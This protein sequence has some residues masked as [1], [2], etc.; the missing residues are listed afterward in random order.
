MDY[1]WPGNVR[2]LENIAER[3][4]LYREGSV[5]G[6]EDVLRILGECEDVTA[7]R[8]FGTLS[9]AKIEELAIKQALE[10]CGDTLEGKKRA[11]AELGI[12]LSGLY[13]KLKQYRE[14]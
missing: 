2:E 3:L 8:S 1:D 10:R 7:S 5:I 9:L 13:K 6:R 11:A 14:I 4:L 12:S